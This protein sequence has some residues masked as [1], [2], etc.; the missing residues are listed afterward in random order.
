MCKAELSSDDGMTILLA[1]LDQSFQKDSADPAYDFYEAFESL[2]RSEG[3]YIGD[4][5]LDFER[6][7]NKAEKLGEWRYPIQGRL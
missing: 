1:K 3:E 4:F 6:T 5:I 7:Y 2:T